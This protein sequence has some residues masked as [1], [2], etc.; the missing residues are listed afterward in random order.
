MA[1]HCI[2]HILI[3]YSSWVLVTV[4]SIMLPVLS[5]LRAMLAKLKLGPQYWNA[6][7]PKTATALKERSI[8]RLGR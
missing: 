1:T 4:E 8:N 2:L 5:A 3:A 7:L 6:L